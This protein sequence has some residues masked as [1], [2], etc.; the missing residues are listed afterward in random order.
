LGGRGGSEDRIDREDDASPAYHHRAVADKLVEIE[1]RA[2]R[3]D[4]EARRRA[5]ALPAGHVRDL[6]CLFAFTYGAVLPTM[7]P[8][9]RT[10]SSSPNTS[11]G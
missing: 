9:V 5:F 11:R 1:K 8:G 7:T 3:R 10:F 6:S 4:R 2:A